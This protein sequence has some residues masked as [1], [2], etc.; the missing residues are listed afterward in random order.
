MN[1]MFESLG[2]MMGEIDK[3]TSNDDELKKVEMDEIPNPEDMMNELGIDTKD[4]NPMDII[5][6]MLNQKKDKEELTEEQIKEMEEFYSNVS[7]KDL[8]SDIKSNDTL[9]KLNKNLMNEIPNNKKGELENI[10]K[11]LMNS[12]TKS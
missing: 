7:T 6:K 9:E 10:T 2:R 4:F 5:S 11:M 12:L 3:K 8:L 1:D